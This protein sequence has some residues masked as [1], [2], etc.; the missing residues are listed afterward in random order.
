MERS[1]LFWVAYLLIMSLLRDFPAI[2]PV[3]I[4]LAGKG[5]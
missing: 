3:R 2:M 5:R 4:A 1:D